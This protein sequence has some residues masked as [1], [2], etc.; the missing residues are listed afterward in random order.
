M[1]QG[2]L[3]KPT[4]QFLFQK[5]FPPLTSLGLTDFLKSDKNRQNKMRYVE[6]IK[7]APKK[8]HNSAL[9]KSFFVSLMSA[10]CQKKMFNV[11]FTPPFF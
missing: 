7:S 8:L 3:P 5:A 1:T 9:K 6:T 10:L 11:G 4:L 2:S